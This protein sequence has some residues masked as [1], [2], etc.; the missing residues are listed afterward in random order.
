MICIRTRCSKCH[1][2]FLAH[3]CHKPQNVSHILTRW[4]TRSFCGIWNFTFSFHDTIQ[5]FFDD[6]LW[7]LLA[8]FLPLS[9]TEVHHDCL[10]QAH[11]KPRGREIRPRIR[12]GQEGLGGANFSGSSFS[13]F[14]VPRSP[15]G[16]L[17]ILRRPPSAKLS[18][19]EEPQGK[20]AGKFTFRKI[21]GKGK[22]KLHPRTRHEGPEGEF[23][24]TST[25][26]SAFALDGGWVVN[27]TPRPL[28]PWEGNGTHCTGG[29]EGPQGRSGWARKISS[30]SGF[31]P[32]TVQP[33]ASCYTDWAIPAH[34][35]LTDT[36]HRH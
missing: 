36:T 15:Y 27:A 4:Y 11:R 30:T 28:Y 21:I 19:L 24:Y 5:Y 14:I 6:C 2:H 10:P 8:V 32:R 18:H 7:L 26:S 22:G 34:R 29:W 25:L 33:I 12:S 35:I 31:D 16:V 3:S 17:L 9:W 23:K 1:S 20:K 13:K